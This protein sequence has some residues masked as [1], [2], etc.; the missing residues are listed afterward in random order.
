MFQ[1]V[2]ELEKFVEDLIKSKME[3]F[4]DGI[5]VYLKEWRNDIENTENS[6]VTK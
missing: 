5:T 4:Y 1:E 2:L 6:L 3:A